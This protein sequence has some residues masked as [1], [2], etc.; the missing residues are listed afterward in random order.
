MYQDETLKDH[1]ETSSTL[2]INSLVIAEWNMNVASNILKVGNY[3][4]RPAAVEGTDDFAYVSIASSFDPD[5]NSSDTGVQFYTGATDADVV[6]DGGYETDE[7]NALTPTVFLSKNEKEKFL[8]SLDDCFGRF[9]PRSGINKLRYFSGRYTH[10]S[11]PDLASRPRYYMADR[12][13]KFKYWT[14]YRTE[15]GVERGIA[16]KTVNGQNIIDDAAPF[17]VY[18]EEVPANRIVVKMQTNVGDVDLG[19][20]VNTS[21][22]FDDPFYGS[23]NQT[24]PISWK[25]QYLEDN[26]WV[27]AISFDNNSTRRD[28]SAII[29]SDGYVEL[30]YGLI[31]PEEYRDIF[32]FSGEFP[33]ATLLP[34]ITLLTNGV[35]YL[36]KE[37]DTDPGMFHMVLDEEYVQF[38]A[39]YGWY[40]EDETVTSLTN[41]VTDLTQPSR[42]IKESDNK[43]QYREFQNVKGLRVVVD[44]MN[45]FES[46]FD[47]IELSPRLT[48]D[49][50][51]KT[52][53]FSITK[54]ASD[55]GVSGLP[56]GQLL[57]STGSIDLFDYDQAFFPTNIR[58][59]EDNTGSIIAKYTTQN[60][61]FKFYEAVLDVDGSDYYVPIKTMYSEGFPELSSVNRSVTLS[62]RDLFFYFE[63]LTAPQ[64]LI[65]NA[66]L[67]YAVSM[68]LDSIGFTNYTFKRVANESDP[69]IPF[70]SVGPDT[71]IAQVLSDLAIS[72]QTA[73]FLDEE[74]NFVTMSKNYIMPG[75]NDRDTEFDAILY[76]SKD[77]KKS[78]VLSNAY[79]NDDALASTGKARLAN[80]QELSSADNTVYNDGSINY[81]SRYIQKSYS[82]I[83]Q[84]SLVDRDKTWIYKPALLWEVSPPDNTKSVNDELAQQSGYT[85]SAIPLNSDLSD[86]LPSVRDHQI[87]DNI[88]DFGDGV[89]WLTR[90]N[91]YFYANGEIIR[92]DAVQYSIPG[93]GEDEDPDVW[94]TSAQEYQRYFARVP[95]NGKIYPTGLVRIY[96]EPNYETVD[97]IT[98]L[99]NGPVAKHGR[100]QYGTGVLG[101]NGQNIPVYHSAGISSYWTSD[102]NVRGVDMDFR[103]LT[104][105]SLAETTKYGS[106]KIG[107]KRGP[108]GI[109]N[110]NAKATTRN[111][112]IKNFLS[113]ANIEE[114]TVDRLTTTQTGTLQSSA[115]VMNGAYGEAQSSDLVTYIHKPL[116]DRFRHFGTRMRIIGKVDNSLSRGQ[117]PQGASTYYTASS[118]SSDKSV[119]IGG[120][121]GGMGVFIDPKTNNGYYFEIMALT[122][123]NLSNYEEADTIHNVMF[124]KVMQRDAPAVSVVSKTLQ[125]NVA[126]LTVSGSHKF[127]AGDRVNVSGVDTTFNS[128]GLPYTITE[129]TES[130][131]SYV[132]EADDVAETA[133]SPAGTASILLEKAIP[134]KLWGG[135]ANIIVDNGLF[136]GQYRVAAEENPTVYDLSVEYEKI[137]NGMRFYLYINN[138]LIK[139]VDDLDPLPIYNGMA[140]FSRG[141]SRVMFENIYA[142]T[143]NYSQNT[144]FSIG[145]LENSAFG[146]LE[147]NASNAFQ[148]YSM[149]GMIQETYLSGI[150]TAEPPK[151]KIY[152]EE[153]GTIMREAAY[154]NVRYDKAYPALY[155]KLAPTFNKIKGYTVSGFAAGAYR[156]EFL[157]FNATDTALS[158][159]STSGNYL[160]ILG[161]T[162]TQQS[163]HELTV[164]EFF[165]K[166]SDASNPEFYGD[167][168]VR[169]PQKIAQDYTDIKFSRLTHG[170]KEFSITAP[171]IQTQDDAEEMMQWLSAKIMK[172]RR[173]VGIK[174]F[175]MPILQLGDIVKVD[176]TNTNGVNEVADADTRFVIYSIE[177]SRD[178]KGPSMTV[179]LS[180]VK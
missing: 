87:V 17:I 35:A 89:Y 173:S 51:D 148:K 162:F 176:Y 144:T 43:V 37:T 102:D 62:L 33:S 105:S 42:F 125:D 106:E 135:L 71:T 180:E 39:K 65:Q 119:S 27:D 118:L 103:F 34:P 61:Q 129:V 23:S 98:R 104:N 12:Y 128:P 94:I 134:V 9:R 16:N 83:R 115:L 168:T 139:Y 7:D 147:I 92:Y 171:Y 58:N 153:F 109:D 80:I 120:S 53:S 18:K 127:V 133:V 123:N 124:Y 132:K 75:V 138:V 151:Y 78:G 167:S 72:T 177:Y 95:F 77:F 8:Y 49:L 76:G 70:F 164:D 90:Y 13:D 131:F 74:N 140:L 117:T 4:Y 157:V 137:D 146:D 152:F 111:G 46:T 2:R 97:G 67:S 150:S 38:E 161:I 47:L 55:L 170:K 91:G 40:L 96:A 5:D 85:L 114:S 79:D 10:H 48:V 142:L 158:L 121:S 59:E 57:A 36:I 136:T 60:I 26:N 44:T 14:S 155:A 122:E 172:P 101:E 165:S 24:T 15:N 156:A 22:T 82:S 6:V 84:A 108:A 63:S 54:S 174:I 28:G 3:R 141:S 29:K 166:K 178:S 32:L 81:T 21:G 100:M 112:I 73:M 56:V 86:T 159:D 25:I 20:F 66:S 143:N 145:K 31:I 175:G 169:S 64:L 116:E 113:S 50:S 99:K 52:Q 30:G 130:T 126:T 107:L 1:L 45:T 110:E 149:S 69:L 154:F 93:L 179:Y 163:Q 88:I 160:R 41:Y 19:P 68:L 11:N